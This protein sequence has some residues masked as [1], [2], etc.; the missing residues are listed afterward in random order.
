MLGPVLYFLYTADL[1]TTRNTQVATFADD[2]AILAVHA[3]PET[4]S[5][6]LQQHLDTLDFWLRKWEIKV[7]TA[8]SAHVT[9]IMRTNDCPPVSFDG[10]TLPQVNEVKYLGLR[11]GRRLTWRTHIFIKRKQLGLKLQK[12]Y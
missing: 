7:N 2:T 9:F 5:H 1:P 6:Y 3:C 4:A 10:H 12:M 8:K 11:I